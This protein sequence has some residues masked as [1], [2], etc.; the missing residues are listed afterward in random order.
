LLGFM[1]ASNASDEESRAKGIK[2]VTFVMMI[3]D[4]CR[5]DDWEVAWV[6]NII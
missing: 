4:D 3:T 1:I 2:D 6:K 5:Q